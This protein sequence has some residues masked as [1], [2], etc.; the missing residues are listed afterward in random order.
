MHDYHTESI[1]A[2]INTFSCI[3]SY[4]SNKNSTI[5]YMA[6]YVSRT[7]VFCIQSDFLFIT[8]AYLRC[9]QKIV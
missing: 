1:F 2:F 4:Y 6:I 8:N 9:M 5:V 3:A 7:C